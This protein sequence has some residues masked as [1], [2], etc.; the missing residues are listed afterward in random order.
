MQSHYNYAFDSITNTYNFTTKN[1]IIYRVAFV[2]DY[3]FS[4]ISNIEIENVFQI[5]VE[6]ASIEKESL[7]SKVA[8]TIEKIIE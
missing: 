6:K 2:E 8:K 7:D 3:T 4:T 1:N 5:V